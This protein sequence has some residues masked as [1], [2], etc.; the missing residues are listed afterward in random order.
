M[1]EESKPRKKSNSSTGLFKFG[2]FVAFAGTLLLVLRL[3]LGENSILGIVSNLLII[4]SG[5]FLAWKPFL[6]YRK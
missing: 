5:V 3:I 6:N 2:A 1:N 4:F